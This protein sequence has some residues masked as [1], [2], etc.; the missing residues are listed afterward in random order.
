MGTN[1]HQRLL[2]LRQRQLI[3]EDELRLKHYVEYEKFQKAMRQS[4]WILNT[5][6]IIRNKIC[7]FFLATDVSTQQPLLYIQHPGAAQQGFINIG[8]GYIPNTGHT[9]N[10]QQIV[11]TNSQSTAMSAAAQ[12]YTVMFNPQLSIPSQQQQQ[13]QQ[14]GSTLQ[15]H[16]SAPYILTNQNI[17]QQQLQPSKQAMST[18]ALHQGFTDIS[19]GIHLANINS[20]PTSMSDSNC[21]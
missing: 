20:H 7:I 6:H 5:L 10:T 14:H 9:N 11:N 8:G 4:K 12:G 18:H 21:K 19:H 3:E 2:L 17:Q 1:Q 15:Q 13:Q 16:I